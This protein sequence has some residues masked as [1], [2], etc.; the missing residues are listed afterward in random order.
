[1]EVEEDDFLL[2]PP[3]RFEVWPSGIKEVDLGVAALRSPSS[4]LEGNSS[5]VTEG[6]ESGPLLG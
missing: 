1:L 3:E 6:M 4:S 5:M 2:R